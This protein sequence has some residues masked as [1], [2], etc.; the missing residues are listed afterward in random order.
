MRS[1][2]LRRWWLA[3]V[4]A[5]ALLLGLTNPATGQS[6]D[7]ATWQPSPLTGTAKALR[8]AAAATSGH[9]GDLTVVA[10]RLHNPRGL[11]L[12]HG[13][14]YVAEAGRGGD[15]CIGEP[16]EQT[17]AGLTSSITRAGTASS[18]GSSPGC[19]RPPDPT[20]PSPSASTTC[21]SRAGVVACS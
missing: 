3:P 18:D 8:A 16:P 11:D 2:T 5:T 10:D 20:A 14:L 13:A 12:R 21:R 9:H 7:R 1:T 19:C 15:T 6:S 17:C 4:A